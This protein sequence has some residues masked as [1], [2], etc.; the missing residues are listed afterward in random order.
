M[1]VVCVDSIPLCSINNVQ[2]KSNMQDRDTMQ[3]KGNPIF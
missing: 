3:T 2:S 1:E